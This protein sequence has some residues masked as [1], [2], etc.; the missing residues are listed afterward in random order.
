[1]QNW[2]KF[3]KKNNGNNFPHTSLIV[4]YY[5]YIHNIKQKNINVLDLGCG[6]GSSLMLF[7]KNSFKIDLVDIS[8]TA[9]K[10]LKKNNLKK[11]NIQ[12]FNQ[13]FNSF[14]QNSKTKYDFIIDSAS[15]QHQSEKEI[16]K[17]FSLINKNLKKN[18][19]FLSINLNSF[20]KI[21]HEAF[22]ATKLNKKKLLKYFKLCN[23]RKIECNHILYTEN[24]SRN[25]IK[26]NIITGQK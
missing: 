19:Y 15:L 6:T 3:F 7:Q 26:F 23:L 2:E 11:K 13:N 4:F 5:R 8:E 22:Y 10:K 20:K 24:N 25:Y 18:G 16:K 9:L 21:N 17:S 14:L 12:T 1:M